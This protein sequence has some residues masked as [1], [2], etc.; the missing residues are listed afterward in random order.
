MNLYIAEDIL[1]QLEYIA[2]ELQYQEAQSPWP[3]PLDETKEECH[4]LNNR[5]EE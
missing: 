5:L 1:L 3:S 4:N 2:I